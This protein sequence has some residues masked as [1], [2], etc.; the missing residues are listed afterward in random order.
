MFQPQAGT[1]ERYCPL[2]WGHSASPRQATS[3][4][5]RNL[6]REALL[7]KAVQGHPAVH[8]SAPGWVESGLCP[9]MPVR[10]QDGHLHSSRG[11]CEQEALS[12]GPRAWFTAHL[13][14]V[15]PGAEHVRSQP[16]LMAAGPHSSFLNLPRSLWQEKIPL[17]LIGFKSI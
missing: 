12:S 13:E 3:S 14:H 16:G 1:R 2:F 8:S 10:L 5:H 9:C 17:L 7:N 11:L 15:I 4:P 6:W